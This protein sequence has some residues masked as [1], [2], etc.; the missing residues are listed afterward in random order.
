VFALDTGS[1]RNRW[2]AMAQDNAAKEVHQF[3]RAMGEREV[4]REHAKKL[5]IKWIKGIETS[6]KLFPA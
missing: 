3:S 2:G 5:A 1:F 4:M 6:A